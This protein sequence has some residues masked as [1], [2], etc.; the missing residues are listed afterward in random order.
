MATAMHDTVLLSKMCSGDVMAQ[1]SKYHLDCL[2]PSETAT[3]PVYEGILAE[4]QMKKGNYLKH[5][6]L[7]SWCHTSLID[8]MRG[9]TSSHC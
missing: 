9:S 1:E 8:W 7:Q 3:V 6:V 5:D 4:K 2:L